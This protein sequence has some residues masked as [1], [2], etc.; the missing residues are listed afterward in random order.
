MSYIYKFQAK[1]ATLGSKLF[2]VLFLLPF[3]IFSQTQTENYVKTTVLKVPTSQGA[4]DTTDPHNA[5]IEVTYFDGLGRPIQKIAHK[6]SGTGNDLVTHIEYDAFGRQQKEYLPIVNGQSLNYHSV[7][8]GTVANYYTTPAFPGLETTHNPYSQKL[9]E[10]SPANSILKQSAPGDDW[11]MGGGHEKKF[12]YL[13]NKDGNEVRLFEVSL[14]GDDEPSLIDQ[15]AYYGENTLYKSVVKDENWQPS[16][17]DNH[18]TQEFKDKEGRIVLKRTFGISVIDRV[19]TNVS[20]DT[21]YVYDNYGNLTYVIPPLVDLNTTID[22]SVLDGLCYQYQYD[23]KNRLIKKKLPGKQ[24]EYI[25]YNSQDLPVA[26]GPVKNPWGSD[27]WGWLITKYDIFGRVVYTGWCKKEVTGKDRTIIEDA[28]ATNWFESYLAQPIGI[29]G[30]STNYTNTTYPTDLKLLTVNFYDH[31]NYLNAPTVPHTIEDAPVLTAPKS[32]STGSWVRILNTPTRAD[33]DISFAFY[34]SKGRAVRNYKKNYL[35][36]RTIVD[37]KLTFNGKPVVTFTTHIRADGA[38]EISLRDDY[39]YTAQER[40]LTHTQQI[41][42]EDKELIAKNEYDDLGQLVSKQVGGEDVTSFVGLQK[43]DYRYNIRGWLTDINDIA[44][45]TQSN[46]P[47]DLFAF[48][49]NYNKLDD[50]DFSEPVDALFNGNIAET[51]WLSNSDNITRKYGYRYD[52]LNRLKAAVYQKPNLFHPVTNMYDESIKYDKNGNITELQRNGDFDY[53]SSLGQLQIDNL[54][55][56]YDPV[57]KNQLLLVNDSST[58]TLG[59]KDDDDTGNDTSDDYTYDANGNMLTDTNKNIGGIV[60]NHLNL[61]IRITFA[62]DENRIDYLYDAMGKKV[63][64]QVTVQGS[65]TAT[66][67]LD[68]FQ[69]TNAI[70]NFFPHEEGY[71]NITY[72]GTCQTQHQYSYDYVYNY[73][74]HLGNIRMSYG[75]DSKTSQLKILE[76]NHYYPFGLKHTN[77]NSGKKKYVEDEEIE[78]KTKVAQVPSSASIMN[79]YKFNGKEWQDELNLNVTAMDYRQY[80]NALGRFN[81]IDTFGEKFPALSSYSFSANNP[82]LLSDPSGDDWSISA[83]TDEDGFIHVQITVN[84]AILNSSGK[85]INLE[86]Y[87]KNQKAQ[88]KRIFSM[89]RASFEVNSTLNLREVTDDDDVTESEHLINILS[90]SN[91]PPSKKNSRTMGRS[92]LGGLKVELN[93]DYINEDGSAYSNATLSHELGHTG[94][95]EHPFEEYSTVE[96]YKGA[97]SKLFNGPVTAPAYNQRM[98][99]LKT[100]FMT[101]PY[102][103]SGASSVAE[104]AASQL[105][106]YQNPGPATRGQIAAIMR[107][108][109]HG[110]LNRDNK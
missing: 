65:T 7:D 76:E 87:I 3:S 43:V 37:S 98:V 64:K 99:D 74:D 92:Q 94:G 59:F 67:Y 81:N 31:Y 8:Y 35:G 24:L 18:T 30:I 95:L 48:K 28:L 12:D 75:Y 17:G 105:K 90:S 49:I 27:E 104:A 5:V 50:N 4:V 108:Y 2:C 107:Y 89:K 77:Y 25:A 13:T 83:T 22:A 26:T 47:T 19:E 15:N 79:K 91:F 93:S 44:G 29:D 54:A 82:C 78:G 80:D 62:S 66:D 101:Y 68:G 9:F 11:K 88:F 14:N 109:N 6:Q 10:S 38:T 86:N 61:P 63:S 1:R 39:S 55:Y 33:A 51:F 97:F 71:V 41:S 58:S 34:D 60:Y 103:T 16:D 32:L 106:V 72:C 36:G 21:Y 52:A 73:V 96:F 23:S 53:D 20:H 45:L 110:H 100:N 46:A 56:S 70:L 85:K 42:G 84:A 69:Y 57:N 102:R 40:L